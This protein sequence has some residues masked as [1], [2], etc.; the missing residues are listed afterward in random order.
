MR[1]SMSNNIIKNCI[2]LSFTQVLFLILLCHYYNYTHKYTQP[3][4]TWHTHMHTR[5]HLKRT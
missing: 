5:H 4:L 2:Y 3:D 1:F